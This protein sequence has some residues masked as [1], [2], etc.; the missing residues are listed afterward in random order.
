MIPRPIVRWSRAVRDLAANPIAPSQAPVAIG[1]AG[2]ADHSLH[3]PGY[4]AAPLSPAIS[5]ASKLWQADAPEP[6]CMMVASGRVISAANS[7]RSCAAG[8]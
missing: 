5:I 3:D 7:A 4:N 6:H 8:L 1:R 2:S